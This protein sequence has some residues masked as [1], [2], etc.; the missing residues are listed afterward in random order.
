[1]CGRFALAIPP[2]RLVEQYHLEQVDV[3]ERRDIAPSQEVLAIRATR[4]GRE[5]VFLRWGLVPSWTR[6]SG[7]AR[8]LINARCETAFEKPSFR[9]SIRDRRCLVPATAF[10]EWDGRKRPHLVRVRGAQ[11]FSM[12]GIWDVW[13]DPDAGGSI[14]TCAILTVPANSAVGAIHD[15]MP[16]IIQPGDEV[17]WLDARTPRSAVCGLFHPIG[18][19]LTE[20]VPLT[21]RIGEADGT[22]TI[23]FCS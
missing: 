16:L 14:Q 4:S 5:A 23:P 19:D 11:L 21:G 3:P 8:G 9:E 2:K 17:L 22:A 13:N 1:M 20:I 18:E 10:Y 15:R 12:A 7:R 6:E